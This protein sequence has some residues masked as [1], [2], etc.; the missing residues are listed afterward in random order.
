MDAK[1][2]QWVEGLLER[3]VKQLR[4]EAEAAEERNH[5]HTARAFVGLAEEIEELVGEIHAERNHVEGRPFVQALLYGQN[6][7][8]HGATLL[9][10]G[11]VALVVTADKAEV[12]G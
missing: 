5:R 12:A 3:K 2:L 6:L 4:I 10:D 7:H 1:T 11:S 9:N 8:V